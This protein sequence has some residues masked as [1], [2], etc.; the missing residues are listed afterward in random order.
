M[1]GLAAV[2]AVHLSGLA[3]LHC[4]V[5]NLTTP[6]N[7]HAFQFSDKFKPFIQHCSAVVVVVVQNVKMLCT[8]AHVIPNLCADIFSAEPKRTHC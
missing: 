4:H 2:V 7:Q 5:T 3:A 1:T 8:I 6:V